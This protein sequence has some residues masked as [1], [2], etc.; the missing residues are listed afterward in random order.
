METNGFPLKESYWHVGE[1][2]KEIQSNL[3]T[4]MNGEG[5]GKSDCES[6]FPEYPKVCRTLMSGISEFSP[7]NNP[8]EFNI[9]SRIKAASNGWHPWMDTEDYKQ[10]YDGMELV[11]YAQKIPAGE[12]DVHAVVLATTYPAPDLDQ[13]WDERDRRSLMESLDAGITKINKQKTKSL[14]GESTH[15]RRSLRLTDSQATIQSNSNGISRSEEEAIVPGIGWG[16]VWAQSKGRDAYC[17]GSSNSRCG[18][19]PTD[20]CLLYSTNDYHASIS[21]DGLS[22]WLVIDMPKMKE[23]LILAKLEFWHPRSNNELTKGWTEVNNGEVRRSLGGHF[24]E[25]PDDFKVDIAVNGKI[26]KTWNFDDMKELRKEVQHN[27][28]FYPMVDDKNL[29]GEEKDVELAIRL[30]S[31]IDPRLAGLSLTHLYY[32]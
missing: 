9:R 15:T 6:R 10:V 7:I 11:P 8:D 3:M 23:G 17:D 12:V 26:V 5:L 20:K 2:Y 16:Y 4:Y 21:G 28:A 29:A 19:G 30:S 32:A 24:S 25:W 1:K 27:E 22:G 18:R 13:S 14:K 31:S